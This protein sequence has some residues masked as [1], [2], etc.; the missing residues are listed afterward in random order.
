MVLQWPVLKEGGRCSVAEVLNASSV[1]RGGGGVGNGVVGRR[2]L[3]WNGLVRL[4]WSAERAARCARCCSVFLCG[5]LGIAMR[6]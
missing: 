1:R 5:G 6:L 2:S 4:P 3:G